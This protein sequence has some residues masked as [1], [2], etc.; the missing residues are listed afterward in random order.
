MTITEYYQHYNTKA[1]KKTIAY[2]IEIHEGSAKTFDELYKNCIA[3]HINNRDNVI[4]WHKML[5]EYVKLPGAVFWVRR[6]ESSS[7]TDKL[8]HGSHWVNRRACKTEYPDGFSYVFVSNFD[9]HEIFN[10][11]RL[12]VVPDAKEFLRLMQNHQYP[13]HYDS[14]DSCEESAIAVYP[15]IGDPRFGV[16][17]EKH[18]YLAH[19]L[20]VNAPN[21]YTC[22]V[23]FDRICPRGEVSHWSDADGYMVRRMS[24]N[25]S[26]SE[27]EKVAAHFLRFV[28][29][30]N[31][32]VVPGK[33]Y[34]DNHSYHF[35]NNQIGEYQLLNDYVAGQFAAIYGKDTIAGFRERVFAKPLPDTIHD[36]AIDISYSPIPVCGVSAYSTEEQLKVVAYYLKNSTGLTTAERNVLKRDRHGTVARKILVAHGIDT[37][38]GTVHKGI[39]LHS[40]I[41]AVI[42]NANG[43]FRTTLEEIKRRGLDK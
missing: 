31:Y 42:T 4:A 12:G 5:L 22:D 20:S 16:L 25:L 11:V 3:Q 37:S 6:Y 24:E 35:K 29:P 41:D 34:Q 28:D 43:R 8:S 1:G 9:A 39:L 10:M 27:K 19:I 13:M 38:S 23:D 33:Y 2:P 17:T 32:Y 18:W 36:E 7:K 21:D 40:N 15:R 30:I 26:Q 14:G